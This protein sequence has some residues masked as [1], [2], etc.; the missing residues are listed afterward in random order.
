LPAHLD[1]PGGASEVVS[2]SL[3][4]LPNGYFVLA[5]SDTV[6]NGHVFVR[7]DWTDG[8]TWT[9]DGA[10]LALSDTSAEGQDAYGAETSTYVGTIA[11]HTAWVPIPSRDGRKIHVYRY[12]R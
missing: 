7:E 9:A 4:L 8:G 2:G 10:I 5:E 11:L 1:F 6:W 3:T 12:E